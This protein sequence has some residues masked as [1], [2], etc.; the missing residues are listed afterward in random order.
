MLREENNFWRAVL[1]SS[2]QFRGA[3]SIT[4]SVSTSYTYKSVFVMH[5]D[6]WS[7]RPTETN[8]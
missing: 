5:Y 8:M 2:L 6:R 7:F 3:S 4:S 1:S